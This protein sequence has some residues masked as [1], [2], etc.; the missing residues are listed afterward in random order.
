MLV[1]LAGSERNYETV[2]MT[3]AMHRESAQINSA[4]MAL[5]D[6]FR[7]FHN[8]LQ[9]AEGVAAKTAVQQRG[10]CDGKWGREGG[11]R[12]LKSSA[13]HAYECH[14]HADARARERAVEAAAAPTRVP[15]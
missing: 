15:F 14:R 7:A 10:A 5:K 6:C 12:P 8:H 1:D 9:V 11:P 2:Q 13:T 4:L 3:P